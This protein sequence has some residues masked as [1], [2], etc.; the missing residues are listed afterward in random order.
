MAL[1]LETEKRLLEAAGQV[2]AER[3]FA[4][5]TV[6]EICERAEANVA[7]INYHFGDKLG[8]YQAV[9]RHACACGETQP[10]AAELSGP[11]AARLHAWTLSFLRG[12]IAKDRAGWPGRLMARELADPSPILSEYIERGARPRYALLMEILA[13]AQPDL[14]AAAL[15]RAAASVIG[16]VIFYHHAKPFIDRLAPDQALREGTLAATAEH[17]TAFS[18]AGLMQVSNHALEPSS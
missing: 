1:P 10:E 7:A 14:A 2:F 18:L 4:A 6:R 16:Q 17:I 11:P 9:F 5:A 15:Q 8:L 12:L 3:G 13:E